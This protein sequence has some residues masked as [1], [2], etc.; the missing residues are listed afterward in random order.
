MKVKYFQETVTW[1][2]GWVLEFRKPSLSD[3]MPTVLRKITKHE[4]LRWLAQYPF[5]Y[6]IYVLKAY[7]DGAWKEIAFLS[8]GG[9]GNPRYAFAKSDDLILGPI[10]VLPEYRNRGIAARM[11]A[12]VLDKCCFRRCYSFIALDN[13]ASRRAFEKCGLR[14]EASVRYS[15]RL[16]ILQ[17][18]EDG[19]MMLYGADKEEKV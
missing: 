9:G 14:G 1:D 6:G 8:V 15:P 7:E 18:C 3:L 10:T 2:E 12:Y 11:I 16:R 5:G 17:V 19:E 4:K 13:M